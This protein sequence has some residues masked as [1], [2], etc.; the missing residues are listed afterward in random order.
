[1]SDT[2]FFD[3]EKNKV[4]GGTLYLVTTPIGNMSDI[5]Y[6]AVK[7]LSVVLMSKKRSSRAELR[8]SSAATKSTSDSTLT[9]R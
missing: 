6:R 2:D 9:A 3:A 1:M 5:T 8:V 7:V 4:I